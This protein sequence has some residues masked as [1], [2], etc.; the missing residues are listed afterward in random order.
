MPTYRFHGLGLWSSIPVLLARVLHQTADYFYRPG[1]ALRSMTTGRGGEEF[2]KQNQ[3]L[4][5]SY[6]LDSYHRPRPYARLPAA[7]CR[8]AW[9]L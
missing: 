3:Y 6:E 8:Q 4:K 7:D 2:Y 9:C 1:P 5:V